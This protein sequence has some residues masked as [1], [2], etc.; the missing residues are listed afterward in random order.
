VKL[1]VGVGVGDTVVEKE[2]NAFEPEGAAVALLLKLGLERDVRVALP[3]PLRLFEGEEDRVGSPVRE[4][5]GSPVTRLLREGMPVP[6]GVA[7][8]LL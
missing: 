3:L 6:V 1:P 8:A 5:E 4:R 2:L 7:V